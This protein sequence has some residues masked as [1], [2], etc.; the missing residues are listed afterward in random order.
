M[1]LIVTWGLNII[2]ANYIIKLF[3]ADIQEISRI[4]NPTPALA[5]E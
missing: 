1:P 2:L 4:Q 3:M 5:T